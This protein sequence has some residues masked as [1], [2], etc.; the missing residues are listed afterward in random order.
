MEFWKDRRISSS[1]CCCWPPRTQNLQPFISAV[2]GG[3]VQAQVAGPTVEGPRLVGVPAAIHV[4]EGAGADG[5]LPQKW[6]CAAALAGARA[7]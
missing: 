6:D 7:A 4:R 2:G 3:W 1:C 5:H